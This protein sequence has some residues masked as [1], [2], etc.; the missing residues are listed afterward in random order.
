MSTLRLTLVFAMFAAACT[1]VQAQSTARV[2]GQIQA[3]DGNAVAVKSREGKD[4]TLH[5]ADNVAIAVTKPVK[6]ED[7]KQGDFVGATARR[8]S[9]GAARWRRSRCTTC[10]RRRRKGTCRGIWSPARPSPAR[11]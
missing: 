10:P 6:F 11:T 9:N 2:R 5:L 4:L 1:A 8:S 3:V 7:I